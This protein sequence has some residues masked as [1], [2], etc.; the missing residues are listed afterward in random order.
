MRILLSVPLLALACS[1]LL[2]QGKPLSGSRPNIVF[3][4]SDDHAAH[5]I[6]A[7]GSRIDKTPHIDRIASK[8]MA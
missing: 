5:A 4:F 3:V 7:C 2:A 1:A 8:G 6:S